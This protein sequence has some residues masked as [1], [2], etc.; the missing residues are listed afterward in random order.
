MHRRFRRG[1]LAVA[2]FALVAIA[3]AV[4][5]AVA[6]IGDGGVINGC[7]KTQNGQLRLIDPAT[8]HCLPSETAISWNQTGTQGP[9]GPTGPQG[10]TGPMGPQGLKGDT[11]ATGPPGATGAKGPTGATGPPGANGV[12]GYEILSGSTALGTGSTATA[13]LTCA[14]GKKAMG[15][16]WDSN[17]ASN[18]DVFLMDSAPT[19]DGGGWNAAI[20]NRSGATV[21]ATFAGTCITAPTSSAPVSAAPLARAKTSVKARA[22]GPALKI[23]KVRSR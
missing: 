5:Y 23:R 3:G 22:K 2:A 7:Y 8:D 20:Q 15:G 4:T 17:A 13:I 11:G 14:P 16:G 10:P 9:P 12:S 19:T 21:T 6:D 18:Q 1:A